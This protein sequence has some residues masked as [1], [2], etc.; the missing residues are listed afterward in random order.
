[1]SDANIVQSLDWS[2]F[3]PGSPVEFKK[4]YTEQ[5]SKL[6]SQIDAINQAQNGLNDFNKKLSDQ[7][8][9]FNTALMEQNESIEQLGSNQQNLESQIGD[10]VTNKDFATKLTGGVVLLS[11]K[12]NQLTPVSLDSAPADY[13]QSDQ[14]KLR[15]DIQ[16]GLNDIVTSINKLITYQKEAK[17]M[18]P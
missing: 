17:Q 16:Q 4:Q 9:S 1:M 2:K 8:Q 15:N 3:P 10:S 13:N 11:E 5:T 7:S 6:N 18:E 14:Q 12:I